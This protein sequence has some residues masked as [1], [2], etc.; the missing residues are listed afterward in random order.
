ML[1][2]A[3]EG[4][5]KVLLFSQFVSYL[6]VFEK[7]LQAQG[8]K[9]SYL[10]G[11]MDEKDR[12]RAIEKF[13][14]NEDIQVFLLSLRA[15][16]SGLNLTAADYV[17][18]ADPWWNPFTMRQAEDRAHRIG[19]NKTVFSYKFI[20]KN[21]IEEKILA[22]QMRKT[23]LAGSIISDEDSILASINVEELEELLS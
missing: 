5:H 4:K 13:Q 2:R 9:Y 6:A 11:S 18:L 19:Q 21:T 10:D 15:G 17:F 23:E 20:T 1:Q 3:L 16:N 14:E 12:Q 22:L 7:M 8:I